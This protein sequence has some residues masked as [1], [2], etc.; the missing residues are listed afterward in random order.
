MFKRN[1]LFVVGA[2]A[3]YEFGL[4]TGK[5][6]TSII[7]EKMDIRFEGYNKNIGAGDIDLYSNLTRQMQV[8]AKEFQQ[9]GW[10]IRDGIGLAQSI[11]DF[12]DIHRMDQLVNHY[13][14]AVIVKSILEAERK[15]S[16]YFSGPVKEDYFD[17]I[18]SA[19]TWIGKFLSMLSRNVPKEVI[20]TLFDKVSFIVFNYD[21]CIE[22]FLLHALQKLYAISE[23]NASDIVQTLRIIH[24]YGDIG[25]APFGAARADYARLAGG[26]STYTEQITDADMVTTLQNEMDRAEA[27]VFLGFAYHDQNMK[28]IEP[29]GPM[30]SKPI[31]GTTFGMSAPDVEVTVRQLSSWFLEK[32]FKYTEKLIRTQPLTCADFFDHF[33]KSL[34]SAINL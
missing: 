34:T 7:K 20:H 9:A 19:N 29:A 23:K 10:L 13:G 27:V 5:T 1:T 15:S 22:H 11:D 16:L 6:L 3:S 21:R 17:P 14:K 31:F 28:L 32:D 8:N 4:P 2:G 33:A 26:I 12:L 24:P 30:T 25:I 18:K